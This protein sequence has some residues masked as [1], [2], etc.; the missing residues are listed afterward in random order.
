MI[1][2]M[3]DIFRV[4]QLIRHLVEKL[5]CVVNNSLPKKKDNYC[6]ALETLKIYNPKLKHKY[7]VLF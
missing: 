6:N 5:C 1:D 2:G 3:K 7:F 4:C